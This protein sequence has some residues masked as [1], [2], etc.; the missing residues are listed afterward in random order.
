MKKCKACK[1]EIDN[2]AIK[3][4]H[5]HTDQRNWFI[6][7]PILTTLFII[8]VIAIASSG[9]ASKKENNTVSESRN[10]EVANISPTEDPYPHFEDGTFVVGKDIKPGTY[11]TREGSPGCYYARLRGFGGQLDEIIGNNNT[12]DP[13]II[14]I[15]ASDKGF[16]SSNCGLWTQDMSSITSSKTEFNDGMYVVGTDIKPGTYKN[17]GKQGCYYSRLSNFS[18]AGIDGIIANNT[19]NDPVLVTIAE[20]DAGFK[21]SNCGTWKLQE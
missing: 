3:C 4:P 21:S 18:G 16:K 8:I 2:K 7:H 6:R 17:S 20:T 9:G 19:S 12:S 10:A 14:T 1:S 5:C 13:A 15:D 11:R